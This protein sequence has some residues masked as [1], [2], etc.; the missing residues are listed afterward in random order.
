MLIWI[1]VYAI[2]QT[3]G[4][5]VMWLLLPICLLS[6]GVQVKGF[7]RRFNT[8]LV[9][10][11]GYWLPVL[12][13][14][15]LFALKAYLLADYERIIPD[16]A[17][18]GRIAE[19][20]SDTG[21]ENEY[22]FLAALDD[23][24]KGV[25]PY[26]YGEL[27]LASPLKI[28][29]GTIALL[30]F[31]TPIISVLLVQALY[32]LIKGNESRLLRMRNYTLALLVAGCSW[33]LLWPLSRMPQLAQYDYVFHS[34]FCFNTAKFGF[35]ALLAAAAFLSYRLN[36]RFR[37]A[38][39]WLCSIAVVSYTTLPAVCGAWLLCAAWHHFSLRRLRFVSLHFLADLLPLLIPAGIAVFYMLMPGTAVSR[40][41]VRVDSFQ[42]GS[43]VGM[44]LKIF[45]A[46]LVA[47]AA[48]L[49]P[50]VLATG[51]A[52]WPQR[53]KLPAYA[54]LAAVFACGALGAGAAAWGLLNTALNSVQL[55][56]VCSGFLAVAAAVWIGV[57]MDSSATRIVFAGKL[58]MVVLILAGCVN[59][60]YTISQHR[61][62]TL[63]G[64]PDEEFIT[65]AT[66]HVEYEGAVG[67]IWSP[68]EYQDPFY[69]YPHFSI[70][71]L[72]TIPALQ[73]CQ[74]IGVGEMSRTTATTPQLE[75]QCQA[76]VKMGL[77][78]NYTKR[79]SPDLS[80]K[81]KLTPQAY[82]R[83]F[84]EFRIQYVFASRNAVIPAEMGKY[85]WVA[86]DKNAG[87]R[88]LRFRYPD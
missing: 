45:V 53:R 17:F 52:V 59:T 13:L 47:A 31:A 64:K 51:A 86:E 67:F 34:V 80:P 66:H 21:Q 28:F 20:L 5:T 26:H 49:L 39:V 16:N 14:A 71:V 42:A 70:S 77:L 75:A 6:G 85:E 44:M 10:L 61:K 41:G 40:E 23:A 68:E 83:F 78:Y 72:S 65:S 12:L 56:S 43:G 8:A 55:M 63:A 22:H 15:L 4:K 58:V 25:S 81:D 82:R 9:L 27:W 46:G 29:G 37:L 33:W 24:Y 76:G 73:N 62:L 11:K 3:G 50:F 18:Y 74:L 7:F 35:P 79:H 88:L 54:M 57:A 38:G 1:A 69:C 32:E 48:F 36:G 19:A 84:R 30:G 60:V 87:L 2:F